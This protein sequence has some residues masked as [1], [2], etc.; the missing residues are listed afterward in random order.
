MDELIGE[1]D[2]PV[3]CPNAFSLAGGGL[4][5]GRCEGTPVSDDYESPFA[6]T[7]RGQAKLSSTWASTPRS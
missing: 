4:T 7:R 1:G 3:T 6:F 5:C 2:I